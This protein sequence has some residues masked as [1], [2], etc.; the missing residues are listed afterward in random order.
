MCKIYKYFPFPQ[1]FFEEQP[2]IYPTAREP[3]GTK[4]ASGDR[5]E[6]VVVCRR[7]EEEYRMSS[8]ELGVQSLSF[9][10]FFFN[11]SYF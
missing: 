5:G 2:I 1:I 8:C 10:K 7:E 9:Y 3:R 6:S 11:N 4:I